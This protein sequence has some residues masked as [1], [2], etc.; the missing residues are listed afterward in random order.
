MKARRIIAVGLLIVAAG[1]LAWWF[2]APVRR[3]PA[4]V[5]VSALTIAEHSG[6]LEVLFRSEKQKSFISRKKE[7][8]G[9]ADIDKIMH[10][11]PI[12]AK[13]LAKSVDPNNPVILAQ[14]N[15]T[16]NRFISTLEEVARDENLRAIVRE[17]RRLEDSDYVA[18]YQK[19]RDVTNQ[20]L[21]KMK[22]P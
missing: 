10:A 14:L 3:T 21:T 15:E 7:A 11:V 22:N 5:K 1:I 18:K 16:N 20:L 6:Y 9:R 2:F 19:F 12:Y 17:G 8:I 13:L 4:S